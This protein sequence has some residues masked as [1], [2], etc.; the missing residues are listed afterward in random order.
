MNR[1][2]GWLIGSG[3]GLLV[4]QAW[5]LLAPFV[6]VQPSADPFA[7]LFRG[8]LADI[9]DLAGIPQEHLVVRS[10]GGQR[11]PVRAE[12]H[13]DD[14]RRL[15]SEPDQRP[16]SGRIG[17]VPHPRGLVVAPGGEHPPVRAESDRADLVVVQRERGTQDLWPA[18]IV[19]IPKDDAGVRTATGQ[20]A[21]VRAERHR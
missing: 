3:A 8:M 4:G 14:D 17:Y 19:D 13:R 6:L 21:P 12:R 15:G 1:F 2:G 16:G 20:G 10:A 18:G 7:G 5:Y 11:A 9:D